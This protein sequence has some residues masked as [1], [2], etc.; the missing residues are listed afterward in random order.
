MMAPPP[1]PNS[2]ASVPVTMPPTTITAASQTSSPTGMPNMPCSEND[3]PDRRRSRRGGLRQIGMR[4]QNHAERFGKD[5][6]SRARLDGGGGK[7][8]AEGARTRHRVEGTED[9]AGDGVEA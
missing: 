2:P 9:V 8:A 4:V 7:M 1:T 3:G 6:R 5:M